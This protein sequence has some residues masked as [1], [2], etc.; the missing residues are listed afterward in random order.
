MIVMDIQ[1]TEVIYS[2]G[3]WSSN[4]TTLN[5]ALSALEKWIERD[6]YNPDPEHETVSK[7][8]AELGQG[9]IT[10][11]DEKQPSEPGTIY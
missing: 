11:Q 5:H 7:V 3:V 2:E 6:A 4:D 9:T 8:L 10:Y 1:G